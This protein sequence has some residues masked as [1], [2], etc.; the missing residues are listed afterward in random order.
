MLPPP[1]QTARDGIAGLL[2][3]VRQ[4]C[5]TEELEPAE[6]VARAYLERLAGDAEETRGADTIPCNPSWAPEDE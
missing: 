4:R 6:L 1:C 2:G 3:R 5:T